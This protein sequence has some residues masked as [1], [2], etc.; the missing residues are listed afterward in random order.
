MAYKC[1]CFKLQILVT[2]HGPMLTLEFHKEQYL[3]HYNFSY[4][5]MTSQNESHIIFRNTSSIIVKQ[6]SESHM[7]YMPLFYL[8]YINVTCLKMKFF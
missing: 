7:N 6:T 2:P 4:T 8:K 3:D 5:W 1:E